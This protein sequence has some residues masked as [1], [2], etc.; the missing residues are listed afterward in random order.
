M[1]NLM[2]LFVVPFLASML[3][4]LLYAVSSKQLKRIAVTMSLIPLA[5]LLY[6]HGSWINAEVNYTW[7]PA[8]SINFHLSVDALSLVFLYLTAIIIPMSLFAARSKHLVS[9][10][11][12][13]G[14]VL[15]LQGLLIGFF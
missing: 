2:L 12:F 13:F 1:P 9:S 8:L 11:T 3:A 7:I 6:D 15:L 5:I 14:L 4:F 10:S